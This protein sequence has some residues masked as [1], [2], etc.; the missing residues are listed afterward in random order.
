MGY[1][2]YLIKSQN[3]LIISGN[4]MSDVDYHYLFSSIGQDDRNSVS[5]I[6]CK[7]Y[8]MGFI[9]GSGVKVINSPTEFE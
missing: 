8:C 6:F 5:L 7:I 4:K 9:T 1:Y 2:V 3:R